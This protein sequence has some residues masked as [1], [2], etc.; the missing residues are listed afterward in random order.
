M[1]TESSYP[2]LN[3]VEYPFVP[4]EFQSRDGWMSYVDSGRGRP[5]VFLHGTPSWSF[6]FRWFVHKLNGSYRC[7]APDHLGFGLSEKPR[8]ADYSPQGHFERFS[9][10]MDYLRLKEATLFL[11]DSSGPIG[12]KWA[13]ENR[14]RVQG[15]ILCNT[16]MWSLRDNPSARKL[17]Q[18]VSH[19]IN[20]LYYR[21][22]NAN[23]AFI[24][25]S[26]FA[27]RHCI[28]K[29]TQVQYLEPHRLERE[30]RGVY[31]MVESLIYGEAFFE[32]LWSKRAELIDIP[33]LVLWGMKDPMFTPRYLERWEETLP[34]ASVSC[35]HG[36]G[37]HI[38]EECASVAV[39]EIRW[40]LTNRS[41]S[42]RTML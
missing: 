13:M 30:R 4:R 19:P 31:K 12:L 36:V 25:P 7:I 24:L 6:E 33:T 39:D 34:Q 1:R 26:L 29:A 38:P 23:P 11:H 17:A 10:L 41:V 14:D 27:D 37:R 35:F 15:L 18:M 28:P 2:W 16:Y 20:R 21:I 3:V 42:A 22:L 5:I 40:F 8:D 32:D 9:E